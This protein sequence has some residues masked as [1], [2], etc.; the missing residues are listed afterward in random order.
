MLLSRRMFHCK[1]YSMLQV[2]L[3]SASV[4][5]YCARD[6]YSVH[7][8]APQST[9]SSSQALT[10]S[11][12][13]QFGKTSKDNPAGLAAAQHFAQ[14]PETHAPRHHLRPTWPAI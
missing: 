13:I 4:S 2:S 1:Q 10:G 12:D 5:R 9:L 6:N 11:C 7:A 3:L 8:V 14:P